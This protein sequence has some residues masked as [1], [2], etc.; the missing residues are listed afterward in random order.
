MERMMAEKEQGIKDRVGEAKE[1]A[2]KAAKLGDLLAEMN[3]AAI[4]FK[5]LEWRLTS[6]GVS[7]ADLKLI[8]ALVHPDPRR[9]PIAAG[10]SA[11]EIADAT[12]AL[13]G[14]LGDTVE[15]LKSI[16]PVLDFG[17]VNKVKYGLSDEESKRQNEA[18]LHSARVLGHDHNALELKADFDESAALRER[19][20]GEMD[21]IRRDTFISALGDTATQMSREGRAKL[22]PLME[23]LTPDAAAAAVNGLSQHLL[24]GKASDAEGAAAHAY[25]LVDEKRNEMELR[26]IY[27]G[28]WTKHRD[29]VMAGSLAQ[30]DLLR[31]DPMKWL[32]EALL[33]ALKKRGRTSENEVKE[34]LAE[35][36]PD[37]LPAAELAKLVMQREEGAESLKRLRATPDAHAQAVAAARSDVTPFTMRQA[38][39]ETMRVTAGLAASSAQAKNAEIHT[40]LFHNLDKTMRD[41]PGA[42]SRIM[43]GLVGLGEVGKLVGAAATGAL[44]AQPLASITGG[45]GKGALR[46]AG[47]FF[48]KEAAGATAKV[49]ETEV[50]A[51]LRAPVAAAAR[52][53]AAAGET[54]L[55]GAEGVAA[56]GA[57]ALAGGT[58]ATSAAALATAGYVGWKVGGLINSG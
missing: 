30:A 41:N 34:A 29:S 24:M 40:D 54:A 32:E 17:F 22:F 42:A 12:R 39:V 49:A 15:V 38:Q 47:S 51:L 23:R 9:D 21:A 57:L 8:D 52:G 2:E 46:V 45:L 19:T 35:I 14:T 44:I 37:P 18:V 27:H 43:A 20:D 5:R 28:N 10:F 4:V 50:A 53:A 13:E 7:A 33:P 26:R 25:G 1:G 6:L 3:D 56:R 31:A 58:V 36:L 16:Q 11:N 48:K 55:A